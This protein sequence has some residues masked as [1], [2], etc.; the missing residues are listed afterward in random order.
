MR[1]YSDGS[2]IKEAAGA[3]AVLGPRVSNKRLPNHHS[4]IFTGEVRAILL[5][6]DIAHRCSSSRFLV[7]TDFLSSLLGM[8]NRDMSRSLIAEVISCI[9]RM[10][11][12]GIELGFVWVQSNVGLAGNWA[13]NIAA[14]AALLVPISNLALSHTDY[15]PVIRT[16]VLSQWQKSWSLE[17]QN[18]LHAVEPTVNII[19]SYCLP[20]REKISIHR[21]RMGQTFLTHGHLLKRDS[22]PQCIACQTRLTV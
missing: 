16:Y 9:L 21:L 7:L 20:R 11:L 4:S 18:K 2:K 12:A 17:T 15:F 14:K 1:I 8:R 19:K 13:A 3:A 22:P 5:A 6:L 10:I